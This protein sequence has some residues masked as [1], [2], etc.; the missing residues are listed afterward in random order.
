MG[1]EAGEAMVEA[2]TE[3]RVVELV[4]ETELATISQRHPRQ[5]KAVSCC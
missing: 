3:A 2:V 5:T 1:G 4:V